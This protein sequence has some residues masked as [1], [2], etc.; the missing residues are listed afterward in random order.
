LTKNRGK[1]NNEEAQK[2]MGENKT[3]ANKIGENQELYTTL[4]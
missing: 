4:L 1:C 2:N 3:I